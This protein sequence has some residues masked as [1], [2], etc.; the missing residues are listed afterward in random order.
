MANAAWS[1]RASDSPT[2]SG[3]VSVIEAGRTAGSAINMP[4]G[5]RGLPLHPADTQARASS[6]ARSAAVPSSAGAQHDF[7]GLEVQHDFAAV[8]GLQQQLP[9][10]TRSEE[11]P[12][13]PVPQ[14][15]SPAVTARVGDGAGSPSDATKYAAARTAA[16]AG[17]KGRI[18]R[19]RGKRIGR[20]RRV[21]ATTSYETATPPPSV[22]RH[23]QFVRGESD[24]DGGKGERGEHREFAVELPRLLHVGQFRNLAREPL[25]LDGVEEDATQV[26]RLR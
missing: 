8:R 26:E 16:R 20:V 6:R 14:G 13:A 21:G 17:F 10:T 12:H 23:F 9:E 7:A 24:R 1:A 19:S 25:G 15:V 11:H 4:P 3:I 2:G 18:V 5:P 22:I